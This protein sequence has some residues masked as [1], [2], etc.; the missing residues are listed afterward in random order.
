MRYA[1]LSDHRIM[2][3]RIMFHVYTSLDTPPC[4]G[5]GRA[6][7]RTGRVPRRVAPVLGRS[8][9]GRVSRSWDVP[10]PGTL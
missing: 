5:T 3:H 7:R 4:R 10:R 8:F 6:G 9:R 1:I 2:F